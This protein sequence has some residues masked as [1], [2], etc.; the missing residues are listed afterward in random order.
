MSFFTVDAVVMMEMLVSLHREESSVLLLLVEL[1]RM[2]V[3]LGAILATLHILQDSR[4]AFDN[5]ISHLVCS[6]PLAGLMDLISKLFA[7]SSPIMYP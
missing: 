4:V 7:F 2:G 6:Q 3:P 1:S 5:L